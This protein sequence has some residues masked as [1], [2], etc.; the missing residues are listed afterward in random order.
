MREIPKGLE[1][2]K[3]LEESHG[4]SGMI[5]YGELLNLKVRELDSMLGC[6]QENWNNRA[7][8]EEVLA[9]ILNGAAWFYSQYDDGLGDCA[10]YLALAV[11][12][13]LNE[14][15]TKRAER[16]IRC[17]GWLAYHMRIVEGAH[18]WNP[19]TRRHLEAI[20]AASGINEDPAD[21]VEATS[22]K[23]MEA[24]HA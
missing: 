24:S 12:H 20:V 19:N 2:E 7:K 9:H 8:A 1:L 13:G 16:M 6:S 14:R 4:L 10:Y 18:A 21:P 5:T 3:L 15:T 17:I 11:T 23:A 22:T